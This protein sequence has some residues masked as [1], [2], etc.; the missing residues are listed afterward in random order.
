MSNTR[1]GLVSFTEELPRFSMAATTSWTKLFGRVTGTMLT[2][3]FGE[4]GLGKTSLVQAGLF[5]CLRGAGYVPVLIRLD[6]GAAT[7]Y[8]DQVKDALI[9]SLTAAGRSRPSPPDATK[10]L[11]GS[12]FIVATP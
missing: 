1:G 8:A 6:P 10:N 12:T 4:S 7:A 5:P 9:R 11:C 3:L 2:V